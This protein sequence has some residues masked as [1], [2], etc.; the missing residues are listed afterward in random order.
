MG[1]DRLRELAASVDW[2]VLALP[3]TPDTRHIIDADVLAA[4]KPTARLI[5]VGR[6]ELVDEDALADA[7]RTG[8]IAGA[9]L[10]VFTVEPLPTDS[11]FWDMPNVI[12]TPHSSGHSAGSHHRAVERFLA[13]LRCLPGRRPLTNEIRLD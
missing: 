2:L 12:V 13:N 11:P 9:G 6:G 7:L 3:L 8:T 10:D 5:N 4:M 1:L